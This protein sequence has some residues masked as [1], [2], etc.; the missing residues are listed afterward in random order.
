MILSSHQPTFL[1][2]LDFWRKLYNSDVFDLAQ[3]DQL[4]V[5]NQLYNV[6]VRIGNANENTLIHLPYEKP[7]IKGDI[8]WFH[9]TKLDMERKERYLRQFRYFENKKKFPFAYELAD[10]F[11]TIDCEFKYGTT[12]AEY[13]TK[14]IQWLH[15]FLNIPTKLEVSNFIK[16]GDDASTRLLNQLKSYQ[17]EPEVIYLSGNG[18]RNYLN[19]EQWNNAGFE[20]KFLDEFERNSLP[21]YEG[22]SIISLI[23]EKGSKNIDW[24]ELLSYKELK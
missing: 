18:G 14:L 1:P 22:M 15:E 16:Q 2:Y 11:G 5:N 23:A 4:T 12:V 9:T 10:L 3:N 20:V 17:T 7:E 24:G 8:M 13:N 6:R 19:L 21:D